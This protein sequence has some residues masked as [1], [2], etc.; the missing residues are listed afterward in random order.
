MN[1]PFRLVQGSSGPRQQSPTTCGSACATVARMLVDTPFARWVTTGEGHP[2]PGVEG[3][4]AAERFAA[5]ERVVHARTNGWRAPG[6]GFVAGLLVS[7]ALV[8][9]YMASGFGWAEGRRSIPY[10]GLIGLGVLAAGI[11]GA[12][13]WLAGRPF[14]TSA[15]GYFKLPGLEEFEL[16]TA[17]GFDLGVFLCVVGAVML[18]LQSLSR[19]TPFHGQRVT[20]LPIHTLVRGRFVMK[21]R[22]LMPGTRGW[23]RSVHTIQQMPQAQPRNT[24]NT[25]SAIVKAGTGREHAA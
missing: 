15:Y 21:D 9:Q 20:G 2:V 18:M 24:D 10:H 4:T 22:T 5:W 23:G 14:L 16:A 19:I 12:G 8:M 13:A 6:G 25:M 17:M 1:A 7:I 11:T 3:A